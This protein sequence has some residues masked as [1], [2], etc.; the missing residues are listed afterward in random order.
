MENK[1]CDVRTCKAACC[2]NV[3]LEIG[4]LSAYKRR[5]A[6]PILRTIDAY[7][8]YVMPITS[9]DPKKNACPFLTEQ[10]R[11]NIYKVRPKVCRLYGT[12]EKFLNC[13]FLTGVKLD[14][15][16]VVKGLMNLKNVNPAL[17]NSI[18]S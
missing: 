18:I 5:V 2:Y 15:S 7:D 10:C 9:E 1:K 16:E 11:C 12:G 3:P 6:R 14:T 4:Y 17:F 13:E 8:G